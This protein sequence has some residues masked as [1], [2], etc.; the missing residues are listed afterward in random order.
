MVSDEPLDGRCGA[1]V[2]TKYG[3][4]LRFDDPDRETLPVTDLDLAAVRCRDPQTGDVVEGVPEFHRLREFFWKD[5]QVTAIAVEEDAPMDAVQVPWDAQVMDRPPIKD[6]LPGADSYRNIGLNRVPAEATWVD[7]S[8]HEIDYTNRDF[9]LDGFCERYPMDLGRCY[10]HRQRAPE[11][12]TN[13]MTHGLYAQRTNY[14]Q[15]RSETEKAVIEA[16]VDA[17]V[18]DAPFDREHVGKLN[19]LYR[20]AI[21]QHRAMHAVNEFV[22]D[23]GELVGLTRQSVIKDEQGN[24]VMGED[25]EPLTEETENPANLPYSRL[26]RDVMS[27]LSKLGV[28]DTPEKQQ[29]DATQSLAQKLSGMDE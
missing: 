9:R 27:K 29:A 1:R 12:N 20:A 11:G 4:E 8:E 3:L 23:D 28:M 22:D 6:D 16:W 13:P 10:V 2:T 19:E 7:V 17:W 24:V 5:Y 18:T 21:D 26:D 14:Y 25:G 15:S